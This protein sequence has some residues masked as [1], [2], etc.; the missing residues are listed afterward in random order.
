VP[1]GDAGVRP[2]ARPV[3]DKRFERGA[4]DR[5]NKII[6]ANC[7]KTFERDSSGKM[8]AILEQWRDAPGRSNTRGG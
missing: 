5:I 1:T 8:V 3:L 7:V 4:E 6:E 2:G